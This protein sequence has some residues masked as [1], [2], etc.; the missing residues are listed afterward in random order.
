MP[1]DTALL[2]LNGWLKSSGHAVTDSQRDKVLGA[3]SS[4]SLPLFLKVSFDEALRWKSY[5]PEDQT[6]LE[7]SMKS[8][9]NSLF[10]RLETL[11]GYLLISHTLGYMTAA[12]EGL[13]DAEIDDIL[14]ID[15]DVLNDVYQY[16][17]PPVR[18]IPPLLWVRA[19]SDLGSYVVSRGADAILVNTWY[20]RQFIETAKERYLKPEVAKVLHRTLAEYFLGIWSG[21]KKKA[22]QNKQGDSGEKQR[23]VP[24]QPNMFSKKEETPEIFNYRKLNELPYHLVHA[25]ELQMLKD[26][27]LL[28]FDFLLSKI[29]G[30]GLSSLIQDFKQALSMFP[31]DKELKLVC[32]CLEV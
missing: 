15:D 26:R 27:A 23:L 14:S 9:I 29:R 31:G 12:K 20:H 4:C 1:K 2:I 3:F 13:S 8:A 32:Q 6:V 25:G 10:E 21:E 30:I 22:F 16:W 17:T 5:T 19:K 11:H 28:N 7:T 24:T 18:R